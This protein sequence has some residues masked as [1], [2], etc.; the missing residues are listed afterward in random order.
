AS[1]TARVAAG[2]AQPRRA[3]RDA[4]RDRRWRVYVHARPPPFALRR[5]D[6]PDRG[7]PGDT[8]MTVALLWPLITLQILM[9][10]FDTLYHHE[11]TE[12]LAW[13]PSQEHELRL[14]AVRNLIYAMLF[15][16]LGWREP[17]GVWAMLII[18]VLAL[19]IAITLMDFVEEDV[20]RKLPASERV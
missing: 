1:R 2:V 17:H 13:R 14:H 9:G 12:R 19:E 11:M 20:R 4:R 5:T 8:P 15:L 6:P 10:A 18:A 7:I 16:A 3:H